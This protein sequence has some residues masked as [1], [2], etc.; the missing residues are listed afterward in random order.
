MDYKTDAT[1]R[2]GFFLR[3]LSYHVKRYL[4]HYRFYKTI[5]MYLVYHLV[6]P[7][8]LLKIFVFFVNLSMKILR[9]YTIVNSEDQTVTFVFDVIP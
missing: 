3:Y 9:I 8:I 5:V 7:Q 2:K 6:H 4:A 1:L